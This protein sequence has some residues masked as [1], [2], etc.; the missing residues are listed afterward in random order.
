MKKRIISVLMCLAMLTAFAGCKESG[1]KPGESSGTKNTAAPSASSTKET[2]PPQ[3]DESKYDY[4]P[5]IDNAYRKDARTILFTVDTAVKDPD[6]NLYTHIY[7]AAAPDGELIARAVSADSYEAD[8]ELS[9]TWGAEF[10]TDLPEKCW[11]CFEEPDGDGDGDL[12]TVLCD[13]VELGIYGGVQK[14]GRRIA[15]IETTDKVIDAVKWT[16]FPLADAKFEAP[17][18]IPVQRDVLI[19]NAVICTFVRDTNGYCEFTYTGSGLRL[20]MLCN[21]QD[22]GRTCHNVPALKMYLDG[23]EY[24]TISMTDFSKYFWKAAPDI[25]FEDLTIPYG[26][27]TVKFVNT[28]EGEFDSAAAYYCGIYYIK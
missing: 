12:K 21:V 16:A 25:V 6:G 10:D 23:E 7:A 8:K 17:D 9:K 28:T 19:E 20:A 13:V 4:N 15:A 3:D 5:R 22:E 26:T 24:T 18:G 1:K 11:I 14:G 27:H 2:D